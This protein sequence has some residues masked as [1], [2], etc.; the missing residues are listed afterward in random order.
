MLSA[1]CAR[2]ELI[3][4][5]R[6]VIV[7]FLVWKNVL[8]DYDID[9]ED[10]GNWLQMIGNDVFESLEMESVTVALIYDLACHSK[11]AVRGVT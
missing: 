1:S 11:K 3:G 7:W 5:A 2:V 9:N 4:T 6:F 10:L 8:P